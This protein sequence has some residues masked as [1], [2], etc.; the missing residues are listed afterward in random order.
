MRTCFPCYISPSKISSLI[1]PENTDVPGL[2]V[3]RRGKINEG[4]IKGPSVSCCKREIAA[5]P[6][7][8]VRPPSAGS[9]RKR[10]GKRVV[11]GPEFPS[12]PATG[13]PRAAAVCGWNERGY[14]AAYGSRPPFPAL[15]RSAHPVFLELCPLDPRSIYGEE[16]LFNSRTQPFA[17]KA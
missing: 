1:G 16:G 14:L 4:L 9:S 12:C 13:D 5:E 8:P 17:G 11:S 2:G 10:A 6:A 3:E 7:P 15:P